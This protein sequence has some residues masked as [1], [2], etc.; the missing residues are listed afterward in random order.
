MSKNFILFATLL[1]CLAF[2]S[3]SSKDE[4]EVDELK[5][6]L[7]EMLRNTNFV[8]IVFDDLY[9]GYRVTAELHPDKTTEEVGMAKFFFMSDKRNYHIETPY[10]WD[11][12]KEV[13]VAPSAVAGGPTVY[14]AR[15]IEHAVQ[16]DDAEIICVSPFVFKDVDFDGEKEICISTFGY[17]RVYYSVFKLVDAT[18]AVRLNQEPFSEIVYGVGNARTLFDYDKKRVTIHEQYGYDEPIEKVYVRRRR[19]RDPMKPMRLVK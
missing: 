19:V 5:P 12:M 4:L 17:N 7:R 6:E 9:M 2:G 14:R 15:F 1:A 11:W 18:R 3:C 10:C 8:K 16:G 13:I